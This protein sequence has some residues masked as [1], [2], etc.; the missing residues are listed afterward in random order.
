MKYHLRQRG[1]GAVCGR[2]KNEFYWVD[3]GGSYSYIFPTLEQFLG[4]Y[5]DEAR[6]KLCLRF[7]RKNM[8]DSPAYKLFQQGKRGF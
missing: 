6:C 7:I 8:A 1:G 5:Y 4:H 3:K 2:V